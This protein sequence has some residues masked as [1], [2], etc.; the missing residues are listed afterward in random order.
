M[1]H[2]LETMFNRILGEA[3]DNGDVESYAN[4][5]AEPGYDN[6]E[7]AILF[8]NWNPKSFGDL[9]TGKGAVPSV[10]SRLAPIAEKLG[11][12]LEWSDE[13][14][15]C[16]DCGRA[17][18][19][20]ADSYS[21]KPHFAL[22]H[23]CELVCADCIIEDPEDYIFRLINNPESCIT[24]DGIDLGEMGFREYNAQSYQTGWHPG[25]NDN[26]RDVM[27]EIQR[28]HGP[29]TEVVFVL[30]STSQ[31]DSRWSAW[32]RAGDDNEN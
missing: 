12:A 1:S 32:F 4:E 27:N 16:G 22:L 13:W 3:L 29:D 19:T 2:F 30:D 23:E 6:P 11:Y 8:A 10:A 24:F 28:L 18:R 25:Q 5:Y 9:N 26:P 14:S 21:W 17:V 7:K 20:S 31:F 15:T